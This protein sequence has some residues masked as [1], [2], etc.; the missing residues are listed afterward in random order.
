MGTQKYINRANKNLA[1]SQEPESKKLFR[2]LEAFYQDHPKST[3]AVAREVEKI[4]GEC[5]VVMN[6]MQ[7]E[8]ELQHEET[9]CSFLRRELNYVKSFLP[10]YVP[11]EP[12]LTI[13]D[14]AG[15]VKSS[16]WDRLTGKK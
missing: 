3:P 16:L 11:V 13:V 7:E 14:E 12:K 5:D 10:G 9:T 8:F 1:R 15:P 6:K 4:R 2:E